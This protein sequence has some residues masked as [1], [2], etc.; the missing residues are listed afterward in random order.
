MNAPQGVSVFAGEKITVN[1][2]TIT[3]K[4]G[5]FMEIKND[6]EHKADISIRREYIKLHGYEIH[7]N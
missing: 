5:T 7:E 6:T 4:A 3:M 2:K 1:G